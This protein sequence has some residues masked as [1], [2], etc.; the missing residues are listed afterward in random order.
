M[1]HVTDL[2]LLFRSYNNLI[3][4][5]RCTRRKTFLFFTIR[6]P[7]KTFNRTGGGGGVI[8]RRDVR[9]W[10]II[11]KYEIRKRAAKRFHRRINHRTGWRRTPYTWI[12]YFFIFILLTTAPNVFLTVE[13]FRVN[14]AG[15][16]RVI[17]NNRSLDGPRSS[18]RNFRR[19][20]TRPRAARERPTSNKI[21]D[22]K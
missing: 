11:I 1:K 5:L 12:I 20:C 4:L 16:L 17:I 3:F 6:I 21:T 13:T 10:Y 2:I 7:I 9:F 14:L 15:F 22:E 19:V 18:G 8:N